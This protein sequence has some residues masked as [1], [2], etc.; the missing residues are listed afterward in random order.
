MGSHHL[1]HT[2]ALD[3]RRQAVEGFEAH[4]Q[5][6]PRGEEQQIEGRDPVD[7]AHQTRRHQDGDV[8]QR[9]QRP[10]S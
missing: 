3:P 2:T 8:V 6:R 9:P 1:H 4:L 10:V 7:A 5:Q